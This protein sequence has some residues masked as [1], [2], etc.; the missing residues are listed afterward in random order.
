MRPRCQKVRHRQVEQPAKQRDVSQSLSQPPVYP[1]ALRIRMT[2]PAQA[3]IARGIS[4]RRSHLATSSVRASTS[5]SSSLISSS[6]EALGDLVLVRILLAGYLNVFLVARNR[7][8]MRP[9]RSWLL[10]ICSGSNFSY[11]LGQGV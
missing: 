1:A 7:A 8:I 6:M 4:K 10:S 5:D 9:K 2:T 11:L 3:R